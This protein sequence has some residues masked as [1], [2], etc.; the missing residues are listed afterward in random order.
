MIV[1]FYYYCTM[2][3]TVFFWALH[4]GFK[5]AKRPTMFIEW[6]D[7]IWTCLG[8]AILWPIIFFHKLLW[9]KTTDQK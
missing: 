7:A 1:V 9:D 8:M 5:Y 2:A 3:V 4:T 6:V